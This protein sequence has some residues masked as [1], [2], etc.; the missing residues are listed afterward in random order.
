M[1]VKVLL[2]NTARKYLER[3]NEP[4]KSA[5]VVAIDKLKQEPLKGN[6]KKLQGREGYRS[7]VGDFRI[8]FQIRK[9]EVYITDIVPRGQAY[10]KKEK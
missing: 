1:R 9:N 3:L 4:Y 8:L 10:T 2:H 5:V 7:K 6:I